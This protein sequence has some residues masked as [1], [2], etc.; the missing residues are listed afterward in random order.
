MQAPRQA[1]K[2]E[3]ERS[4]EA[5][6]GS[7]RRVFWLRA[8]GMAALL[9]AVVVAINVFSHGAFLTPENLTNSLKKRGN[10]RLNLT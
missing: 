6:R 7:A 10:F 8:G 3:L 5:L 2:A 9:L 1:V 4:A